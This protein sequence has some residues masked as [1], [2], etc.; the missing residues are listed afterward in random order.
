MGWIEIID[1]ILEK[2]VIAVFQIGARSLLL[3]IESFLL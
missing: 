2:I 1:K 3:L